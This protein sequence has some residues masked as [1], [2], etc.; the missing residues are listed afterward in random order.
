MLKQLTGTGRIWL[1]VCRKARLMRG[2]F[3]IR[4]VLNPDGESVKFY[5]LDG[6]KSKAIPFSSDNLSEA[7]GYIV[8]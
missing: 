1:T 8:G 5:I 3:Q 2:K 7:D 4:A 6:D